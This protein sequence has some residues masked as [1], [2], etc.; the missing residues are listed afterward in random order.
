VKSKSDLVKK[1]LIDIFKV[2]GSSNLSEFLHE[3]EDDKL[4]LDSM[5]SMIKINDIFIKRDF[6][7]IY[8][9]SVYR[10]FLYC[11][12]RDLK[13][14]VIVETGVLH[15]L[16]SAW[17]L[18]A[19]EDNNHG[20]LIS[21]DLPRRDWDKYFKGI[22]FGDGGEAE[23]EIEEETPG[24]VVPE[25]LKSRWKLYLG[26]TSEHLPG[27]CQRLD[28]IDLFIHDSDHSYDTMKLE[29]ELIQKYHSDA[30]IVIDDYYANNYAFDFQ[31]QT[32]R[33]LFEIDDINDDLQSCQG[34]A[35]LNPK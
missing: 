10:N 32:G 26:P 25:N 16:T 3:L 33:N 34:C 6:K 2:I 24:W 35:L 13:P 27:I 21:V 20:E 31:K 19:L 4:F 12:I 30:V 5:N 11:L 15:G 22:D 18:K 14:K 7:D 23:F 9:F 29:C 8:E 17:L 28:N 1:K